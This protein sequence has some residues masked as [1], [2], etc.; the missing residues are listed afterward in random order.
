MDLIYLD[1]NCF[2]RGFDDLQQ[3]RIQLEA[4]ACQEI[5]LRAES[6]K[7]TLVWSFMHQ[8]ETMICPFPDRQYEVSRLAALCEVKVGPS[9]EIYQLALSFQ[10]KW[11]LSS[12]D[13]VHLACAA[14]I[15]ADY[16][17]T[18]DDKLVKQTLKIKL[19]PTV[20]NPL[21]YLSEVLKDE[22]K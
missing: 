8:D 15:K 20:L 6:G 19:K 3:V 7:I 17:L 18:C 13:A 9:E 16:L 11:S 1:Y 22:N 4:L 5:F 10:K 2:Q 12:K 14:M 21:N